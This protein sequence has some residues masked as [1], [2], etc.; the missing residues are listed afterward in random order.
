LDNSGF[1]DSN[2]DDGSG[3]VDNGG[4]FDSGGDVL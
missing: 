3:F 4:G 2:V 1:D